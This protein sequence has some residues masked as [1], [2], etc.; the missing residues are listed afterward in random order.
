MSLGKDIGRTGLCGPLGD[1]A[2]EEG[3][4]HQVSRYKAGDQT[5]RTGSQEQYERGWS[6]FSLLISLGGAALGLLDGAE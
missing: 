6:A 1:G 5:G 4:P 2:R 3:R